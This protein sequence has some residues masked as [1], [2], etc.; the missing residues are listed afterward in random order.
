MIDRED[1]FKPHLCPICGKFEFLT[2]GSYD[3]CEECGWEDD[4]LQELD[5]MSGGA[6][7]EGLKGYRALYQAGKHR[8]PA[9]ER[10]A[11]LLENGYFQPKNT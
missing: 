6:N 9:A 3:V 7:W 5:P 10:R 8:L 4:S 1:Y 11:W 2:R